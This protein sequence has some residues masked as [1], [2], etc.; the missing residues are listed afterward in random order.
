MCR[1]TYAWVHAQVL[2][3]NVMHMRTFMQMRAHI[4]VQA[5]MHMA[6]TSS[7]VLSSIMP[8]LMG[9]LLYVHL[10]V[11][12]FVHHFSIPYVS[13]LLCAGN[14]WEHHTVVTLVKNHRSIC[15]ALIFL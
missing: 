13:W 11:I 3:H 8:A 15:Q 9:R 12:E 1:H 5:H 6:A 2:I 7:I 10:E 4:H 14:C